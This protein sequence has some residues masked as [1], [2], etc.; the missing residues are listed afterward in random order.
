MP[1]FAGV[2]YAVS[3]T[4]C[5]FRLPSSHH[6]VRRIRRP[7]HRLQHHS[8]EVRMKLSP[9]LIVSTLGSLVVIAFPVLVAAQAPVVGKDSEWNPTRETIRIIQQQ[10]TEKRAPDFG[11]CFVDSMSQSWSVPSGRSVCAIH[12]E[13]RISG[14]LRQNGPCGSRLCALSV[15]SERK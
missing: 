5:C 13:Y 14:A 7:Q 4:A 8:L 1:S 2:R 15:P 6:S 9:R 10:C 12:R 11:K 3:C